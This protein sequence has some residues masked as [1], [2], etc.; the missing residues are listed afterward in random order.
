[1]VHGESES[2]QAKATVRL[3]LLVKSLLPPSLELARIHSMQAHLLYCVH[4]AAFSPP[5]FF[6]VIA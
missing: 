5:S 4:G 6:V 1:L 2:I 3:S